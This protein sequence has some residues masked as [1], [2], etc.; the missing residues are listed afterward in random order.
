MLLELLRIKSKEEYNTAIVYFEIGRLPLKTIRMFRLLKCWFKL[1]Q[2]QNCFLQSCH[3]ML[4]IEF[5]LSLSPAEHWIRLSVIK[6][7]FLK[8]V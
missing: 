1:F 3:K 7:S 2:S 5:E 8:L 4:Y 6:I